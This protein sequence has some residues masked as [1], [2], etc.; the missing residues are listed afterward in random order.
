MSSFAPLRRA[1]ALPRI[2]SAICFACAHAT[3]QAA[4]SG[5]VSLVDREI[6][7]LDAESADADFRKECD[8]NATMPS[9]LVKQSKGRVLAAGEGRSNLKLKLVTQTL[10][11]AGGGMWSGPKWLVIEGTLA[12]GDNVIGT[13]EARRQS[14]RGSMSGCT[15]VREL[16]QD[17]A[18]DIVEWLD[19]PTRGAK[20][21]D[22]K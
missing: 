14:I 1:P 13:F 4:P 12:D 22:A 19:A 6:P 8:W 20:L 7:Y 5:P 18:D 21:G 10:R 17:I 16:G 2:V 15:T 9:Y 11:T 3:T